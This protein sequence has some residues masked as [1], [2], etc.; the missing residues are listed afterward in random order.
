MTHNEF[1]SPNPTLPRIIAYTDGSC[2]NNRVVSFDN[3]A[4]WGF[5]LTISESSAVH[6]QIDQTWKQSWGPVKTN[7]ADIVH[8]L[9]GSNNTGEL[10]ALIELFD[11][12]LYHS[13]FPEVDQLTVYTD[14]QYAISVLQGDALPV[15]HH[16]LVTVAQKYYTAVPCKYRT[17]LLK[18]SS[19]TGIPGNE[20]A[21]TLAKRGV[22]SCSALGRFSPV[23]PQP[24]S[25]PTIDFN[26]SQWTD[27]TTTE[28]D[29][30]LHA[31]VA[32]HLP[33]IPLLPQTAKK[34]CFP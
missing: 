33:L 5:A 8:P 17:I 11:Y 10:K 26:Q 21:D 34:P 19:H 20:L 9:L 2:P 24:L 23:P 22:T 4:G 6:P 32:E 31:L 16:Q 1:P 13:P 3:P 15:T 7:P 12:L 25:P 30:I 18:V 14:S 29:A 28:Q 27:K